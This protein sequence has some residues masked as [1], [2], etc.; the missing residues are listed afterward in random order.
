[1]KQ[2]H[3]ALVAIEKGEPRSLGKLLLKVGAPL[4]AH[5]RRTLGHMMDPDEKNYRG[6]RLV[7]ARGRWSDEETCETQ[8]KY[9]TAYSALVEAHLRHRRREEEGKLDKVALG[10]AQ[11]ELRAKRLP[12]SRAYLYRC[13]SKG[14]ITGAFWERL[15][16][17]LQKSLLLPGAERLRAQGLRSPWG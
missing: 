14:G 8:R 13:W 12:H 15:S 4:P 1:M 9:F 3:A 7:V 11:E 16:R 17:K 2:W 5:V 6:L 10:H